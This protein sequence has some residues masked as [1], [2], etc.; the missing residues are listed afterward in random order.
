MKYFQISGLNQRVSELILGTATFHPSNIEEM[1]GVLDEYIRLGGNILDT[2]QNYGAGDSEKAIGM[3][4]NERKNRQDILILTKGGHPDENGSRVNAE[5]IKYDLFGSLQRLQTDYIDL[6]LLHRDDP[7][8][9]V[10]PIVEALNEHVEQGLIKAIGVSNWSCERIQEAN[11]YAHAHGL[12]GFS[13]SSPHLSL[14]EPVEPMW[15]GCV[16]AD[17]RTRTWHEVTQ[18]PLLSW[19]ALAG[20]FFTGRFLP[21]RSDHPD[22][23]RVYYS[24]ENWERYRR[25][26]QLALKKGCHTLHIAL[27][28][29]LRQPFPVGGIIGPRRVEELQSSFEATRI[30]LSPEEMRWLNLE[31]AS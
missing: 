29:V 31:E 6:Y 17:K 5:A 21:G 8:V 10:E 24:D 18:F 25:A 30:P 11:N 26:E 9:P 14:A 13:C 1:S 12:V 27:A 2:A 23:V 20:G 7:A 15:P 16:F 22:I 4:L 28:Y 3:W 19:S